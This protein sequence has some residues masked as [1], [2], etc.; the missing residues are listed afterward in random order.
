MLKE[1]AADTQEVE[2]ADTTNDHS[3]ESTPEVSPEVDNSNPFSI[4]L[5]SVKSTTNKK[6]SENLPEV[7]PIK[8]IIGMSHQQI[9][10]SDL[11]DV[12]IKTLMTSSSISKY[13][14]NSV[15]FVTTHA[16]DF[17]VIL[18]KRRSF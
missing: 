16:E 2:A 1:G 8:T 10:H 18:R 9:L 13:A 3:K 15:K 11:S 7:Q 14:A 5:R 4:K 6:Y 17:L 12:K